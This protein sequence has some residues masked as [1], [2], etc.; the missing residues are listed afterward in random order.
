MTIMSSDPR[1]ALPHAE[2]ERFESARQYESMF[3]ALIPTTQRVI[4][5]FDKS[6][7]ASYNASARCELLRA[8]LRADPLNR[9]FVVL[10]ETNTIDRLCPRFVAVLQRFSHSAKVRQTPR[11][12]R[13][14][15]D[16]F[17]IFDASHY[18][19]RFHHEHMRYARGLNEIEGTQQLLERYIAGL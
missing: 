8:F 1:P 6:L 7:S 11:A 15:Y 10:H 18:L 9:L 14:L 16:A 17:V 5:V 19:H 4:R 3:D 2:Y 13:H 12:A